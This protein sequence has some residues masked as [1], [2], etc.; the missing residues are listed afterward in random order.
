[1]P[2]LRAP[3]RE[4]PARPCG[5]CGATR[6]PTAPPA[7]VRARLFRYRFSSWRSGAQTGAWWERTLVGEYV[8][9][10]GLA[11]VGRREDAA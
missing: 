9:P 8:P 11:D 1:M 2:F 7:Y 4:R 3:A 6:F 10:S 5:C